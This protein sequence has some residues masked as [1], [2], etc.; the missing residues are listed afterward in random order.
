MA[1]PDRCASNAA[2]PRTQPRSPIPDPDD[3]RPRAP[4]RSGSMVLRHTNDRQFLVREAEIGLANRHEN[5]AVIAAGPYPEC[6]IG[7]IGGPKRVSGVAVSTFARPRLIERVVADRFIEP[8]N[9]LSRQASRMTSR[10]RLACSTILTTR[11]SEIASS[12]TSKSHSSLASVG[13]IWPSRDWT[14]ALPWD[15]CATTYGR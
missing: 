6:L 3:V 12:S 15:A 5:I 7:V 1:M 9:G 11:S 13:T 4:A 10:R 8:R 14:F 2:T